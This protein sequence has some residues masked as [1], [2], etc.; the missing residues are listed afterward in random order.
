M[1]KE[2]AQSIIQELQA[3]EA[4][5]YQVSKADFLV[6][7]EVLMAQNDA[8]DFRGYAKHGGNTIYTYEPGWSK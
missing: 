2:E 7:R 4:Q 8:K 3:G 6:F 1:T 5:S